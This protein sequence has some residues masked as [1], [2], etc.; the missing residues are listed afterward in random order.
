MN[1]DI[2]QGRWQQLKGQALTK[3][4]KLTNDDIDMIE[5]ERERLVGKIRERYGLARDKAE[6]EVDDWLATHRSTI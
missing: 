2:L 1:T 3:W 5:G 4:G 6:R